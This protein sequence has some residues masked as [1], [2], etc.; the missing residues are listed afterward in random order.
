MQAW[1]SRIRVS[2]EHMRL[3]CWSYAPCPCRP[4][5]ANAPG[6]ALA[7][8]LSTAPHIP[9]KRLAVSKLVPSGIMPTIL[10]NMTNT[11]KP[12]QSQLGCFQVR[13]LAGHAGVRH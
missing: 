7:Q 4:P 13:Q 2:S 10:V 6:Q 1:T 12:P 5:G 11:S 3:V 8:S 9:P